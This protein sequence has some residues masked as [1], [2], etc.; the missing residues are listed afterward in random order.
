MAIALRP[1]T[2]GELLD[3]TFSLYRGHFLLFAGIIALPHLVLL[4]FQLG[5]LT[6]RP[7]G[8]ATAIL[9][10]LL[11]TFATIVIYVLVMAASQAATVI[12]VSQVHLDRPATIL[13]SFA[14]IKGRLVG[15]TGIIIGVG[16]AVGIGLL[17][18]VVP[19]VILGL[20][21]SLTIPVAVLES[22]GMSDAVSRSQELTKGHRGRIFLIW[23][24]F[25]FLSFT[26]AALFQWPILYGVAT[27]T[28]GNP[29]SLAW[30]QVSSAVTTFIS[31]CLVAPLATIALA[32][33]YYDE[34]VRKE[35][36]D[37]E[38][39]MATLDGPRMEAAS[40]T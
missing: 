40:A 20:M 18:L 22:K 9:G 28:R 15:I 36:F 3:R 17:L 26:I 2:I 32:L 29:S 21:W 34:R 19:G 25:A 13:D 38:L 4:A 27:Y 5:G 16:L 14:R 30:V 39:M 7:F 10:N 24:L 31:Q 35:A 33:V 8:S 1:L 12:A 6:F 11:W 37:L 23:F